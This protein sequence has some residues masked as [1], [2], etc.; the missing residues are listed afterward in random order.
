MFSAI[1]MYGAVNYDAETQTLTIISHTQPGE[2]ERYPDTR[3][4]IVEKEDGLDDM[5]Y[6]YGQYLKY[7]ETLILPSTI[8]SIP[9]YVFKNC[10]H[11]VNVNWDDLVNLKTIGMEAFM[12][13]ALGPTLTIPNSVETIKNGAFAM[14][15]NIKTLIFEE[16]SQIQLIERNAFKQSE[17]AEGKLSDVYINVSPAREIVCEHMAFDKFHTAAQTQMGTVMTRLHYP[18]ELFEYYVG[19]Y[20]SKLYDQ[21][22]DVVDEYGHWK[23]D[24]NGQRIH[25]YGIVTQSIINQSYELASNGWQEFFSTGIPVGENSLYRTYSDEVAYLVPY[26]SELQIYLV[27][28]YDMEEN[29]AYCVEMHYGDLIPAKTGIIVH[30]NVVGT[31]YLEY[32]PNPEITVPYN[33]ESNPENKYVLNGVEYKNYLKP[34]NGSM[35]IDN[36]EIVNGVKT[37]RNFFFN[38]GQTAATR[39]GPDWDDAYLVKGWGFFRA[40]SKDYKVWNKAF[41]HLPASMTQSTTSVI[42]DSG[43]LPQD[44]AGVSEASSFSMF[45][46]NDEE[47]K[48]ECTCDLSGIKDIN[49]THNDNNYYTLQGI[50][51]N[52]PIKGIYIKNGKKIVIK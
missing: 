48:I 51:V 13:T 46:A 28:D 31:I 52:N 43:N 10:E 12:N 45:V 35:H 30:S 23:L 17:S 2:I 37:Y 39:K 3:I 1:F 26:T 32:V 50:K 9:A 49:C 41:L 14:C 33:N 20:K 15:N 19:I 24:E 7:L 36:V 6:Q 42:D 25:S 29:V 47:I 8:T 11:L 5:A 34:I 27:Y 16:D 38:N 18:P 22:Y 4:L 21:N 44:N 40:V